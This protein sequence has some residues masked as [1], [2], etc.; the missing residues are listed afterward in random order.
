MYSWKVTDHCMHCVLI[1]LQ[2]PQHCQQGPEF[3]PALGKAFLG[4]GCPEFH[5]AL[6]KAF[7]CINY[8]NKMHEQ[9]ATGKFCSWYGLIPTLKQSN[10]SNPIIMD[11]TKTTIARAKERI[12]LHS[13]IRRVY[14]SPPSKSFGISI[15]KLRVNILDLIVHNGPQ[16]TQTLD[17]H[18]IMPVLDL[19]CQPPIQFLQRCSDHEGESEML[20]RK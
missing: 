12:P 13:L 7:S 17:N 5:L 8:R 18:P 9:W 20:V 6:G 1:Y 4:V 15:L 14:L 11:K 10:Y 2:W 19:F 16:D 3:H